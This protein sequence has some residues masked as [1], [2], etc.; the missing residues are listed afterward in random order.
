[1]QVE[2]VV[3]GTF[4]VNCYVIWHSRGREAFVVDPGADS[5]ATMGVLSENALKPAMYLLTHGH[6]D[7]VGALADMLQKHP[8]PVAMHSADAAWAFGPENQIQPFYP[9][10][11]APETIAHL[12]N[13][14]DALGA[15]NLECMV[16]ATP[17][18]TPGSVCFYFKN[19]GVLLSGDTLFAG[20]VGR[21]DLPGGS[22]AVLRRSLARLAGLPENTRVMPGHGDATT[23]GHERAHN[24]FMAGSF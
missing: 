4:G 23:I 13:D 21:T 15:G 9:Q 3:V 12:L 17:G 22:E 10:P 6:V 7:H 5:E 16:V 8:A 18:H 20:T 14:G 19:H 1:M 2:T 11:R 24:P